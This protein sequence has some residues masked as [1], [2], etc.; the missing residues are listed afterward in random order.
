VQEFF[1]DHL[2]DH[3]PQWCKV[4][5]DVKDAAWL[6]MDAAHASLRCAHQGL[7]PPIGNTKR[8]KNN[9]PSSSI[10]A[11]GAGQQSQV[12]A[13]HSDAGMNVQELRDRRFWSIA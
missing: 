8:R 11:Q 3:H 13:G 1:F 6:G 5:I 9:H 2:V 12:Y 7:L 10:F 4:A